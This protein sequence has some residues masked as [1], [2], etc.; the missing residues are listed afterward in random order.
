HQ[1]FKSVV[2]IDGLTEIAQQFSMLAFFRIPLVDRMVP[3][4]FPFAKDRTQVVGVIVA[5][6]LKQTDRLRYVLNGLAEDD[7]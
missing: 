1:I 6:R 2:R 5:T 7:L 3:F 4:L